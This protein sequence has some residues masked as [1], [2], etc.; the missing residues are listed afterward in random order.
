MRK[1]FDEFVA[2]YSE[3]VED[4]DEAH[5]PKWAAELWDDLQSEVLCLDSDDVASAIGAMD[6]FE[7]D[8]DALYARFSFSDAWEYASSLQAYTFHF[9]WRLYAIAFAVKAYDNRSVSA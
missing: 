6:R 9:V 8:S 3:D 7:P 5:A 1:C 2:D 4:G